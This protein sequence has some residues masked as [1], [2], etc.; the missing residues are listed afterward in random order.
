MPIRSYLISFFINKQYSNII[1]IIDEYNI[2]SQ[3]YEL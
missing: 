3:N 1:V 2:Y